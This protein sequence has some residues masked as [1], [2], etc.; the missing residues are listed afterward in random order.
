MIFFSDVASRQVLH[1]TV[2]F[3]D[4]SVIGAV[5]MQR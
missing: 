5:P 2:V 4:G 1:L 3:G